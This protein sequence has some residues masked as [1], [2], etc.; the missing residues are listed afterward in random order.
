MKYLI[1]VLSILLLTGCATN[2]RQV[3]QGINRGLIKALKNIK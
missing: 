1:G 2:D 3:N